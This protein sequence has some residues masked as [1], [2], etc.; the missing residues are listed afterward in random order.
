MS[1][2]NPFIFSCKNIPVWDDVTGSK[3]KDIMNGAR[4]LCWAFLLKGHR[5]RKLF[6]LEG[7]S[8]GHLVQM[9]AQTG[10]ARA[11]CP[12]QCP[13]RFRTTQWMVLL[14]L[15]LPWVLPLLTTRQDG[16]VWVQ[17]GRTI[18]SA[19]LGRRRRRKEGHK[20]PWYKQKWRLQLRMWRQ[21]AEV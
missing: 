1:S 5:I 8:S 2:L 20:R 12:G 9:P 3:P 15:P 7:T 17:G 14:V 4:H 16:K 19:G 6:M 11:G 21:K 18:F 10:S 13:I